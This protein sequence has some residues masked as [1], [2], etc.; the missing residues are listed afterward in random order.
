MEPGS[1]TRFERDRTGLEREEENRSMGWVSNGGNRSDER[2]K[3]GAPMKQERAMTTD[4]Q[5]AVVAV[6]VCMSWML[7]SSGIVLLNKFLLSNDGFHFPFALASFGMCFSTVASFVVVRVLRWVHTENNYFS[8]NNVLNKYMPVGF[9]MAC[10][11]FT[12]NKVYLYLT[13]SFIQMLK[14]FT[15]V[16]TMCFLFAFKMEAPT[17]IMI[18]STLGIA[19]GTAI[20]SAGEANFSLTGIFYMMCSETAEALRLVLTQKLMAGFKMHP[21]EGLMYLA[22]ACAFW[23]LL[24]S[25]IFEYPQM[26]A[27]GTIELVKAHP[28][29][30]LACAMM[31]FLTN[32]LAFGVIKVTS[33]LTLK[34]VG[35]VKNSATVLFGV[36]LFGDVVTFTQ[37]VGYTMSTVGFGFYNYGKMVQPPLNYKSESK[38]DVESK[39]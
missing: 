29:Y 31:G 9:L 27:E 22:P 4:V 38:G 37:L 7:V 19:V 18:L 28:H 14:A 34:V 20:S 10:T 21:I 16:I 13:V 3:H 17:Q 8:W 33:S 30:Y 35:T 24:G 6:A 2:G 23:L 15:P 25:L 1:R 32:A 12:G 39:L 36:L 11:L 26:V 5:H